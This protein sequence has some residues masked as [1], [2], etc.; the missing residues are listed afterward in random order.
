[1]KQLVVIGVLCL[2]T[3]FSLKAEARGGGWSWNL[4][5]NNP[6][7]ALVGLNFLYLGDNFGFEIGIGNVDSDESNSSINGAASLKY[8]FRSGKTFRPYIQGGTRTGVSVNSNDDDTSAGAS[9]GGGGYYGAGFFLVGNP[10][11]FYAS[12]NKDGGKGDGTFA[13]AGIGFDF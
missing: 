9:L 10:M 1:M 12:Y 13:Q 2:T 5:Y 11:Y 3:I 6:P 7:G 4:G 8:L